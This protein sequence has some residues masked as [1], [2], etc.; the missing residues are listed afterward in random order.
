[1]ELIFHFY[2]SST[3][4]RSIEYVL[5][6]ILL[7]II[8]DDAKKLTRKK[9]SKSYKSLMMPTG[10]LILSLLLELKR[11]IDEYINVL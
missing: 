8:T 11:S 5:L 9:K 10:A 4:E 6:N 7:N 1:M 3:Y 2:N